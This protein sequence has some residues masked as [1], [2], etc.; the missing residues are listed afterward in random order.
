MKTRREIGYKDTQTKGKKYNF[1]AAKIVYILVLKIG[2]Y[3]KEKH[4]RKRKIKYIN[5]YNNII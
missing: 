2:C 4:T 5:L 1:R 3:K